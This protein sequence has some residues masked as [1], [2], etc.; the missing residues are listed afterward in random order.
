[1]TEFLIS[2][3]Y[4][5]VMGSLSLLWCFGGFSFILNFATN[6]RVTLIMKIRIF[7]FP[8]RSDFFFQNSDT[9]INL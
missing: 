4:V 1:M 6:I 2:V 9:K 7:L 5:L 8:Q 3:V